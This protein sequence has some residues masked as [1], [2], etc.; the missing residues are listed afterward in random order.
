[1]TKQ[2]HYDLIVAWANGASVEMHLSDNNWVHC[3]EPTWGLYSIYRIKPAP[4]P[5]RVHEA[6][7]SLSFHAGPLLHPASP[8]ESNIVLLFDG[9]TGKLKQCT[10]KEA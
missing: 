2:K 10:I 4:K 1:M 7:I 8:S 6:L 3:P 9:E 5:D